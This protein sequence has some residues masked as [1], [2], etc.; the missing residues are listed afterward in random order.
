MTNGGGRSGQSEAILCFLSLKKLFSYWEQFYIFKAL[1]H[2]VDIEN[3]KLREVNFS[4]R[5]SFCKEIRI[6]NCLLFIFV[7]IIS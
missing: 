3:Q 2:L 5:N 1:Y 6:L 7:F 4:T